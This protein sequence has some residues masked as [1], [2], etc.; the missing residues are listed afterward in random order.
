MKDL[1][2]A[3]GLLIAGFVTLQMRATR[4]PYDYRAELLVDAS[5]K[6]SLA[7]AMARALELREQHL[8]KNTRE[9]SSPEKT[10][11]RPNKTQ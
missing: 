3:F 10:K 4:Q 8:K 7:N 9:L 11:A 6:D 2:L 1:Y 5:E